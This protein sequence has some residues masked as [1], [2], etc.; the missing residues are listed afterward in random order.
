MIKLTPIDVCEYY[1]TKTAVNNVGA[2]VFTSQIATSANLPNSSADNN[3][4]I[5]YV[6][7]GIVIL[8][9]LYAFDRYYSDKYKLQ[10]KNL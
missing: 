5:Y 10:K 1:A 2:A 7:G 9:A 4:W 8:G 3:K 6:V